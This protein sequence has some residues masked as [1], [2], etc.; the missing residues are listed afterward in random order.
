MTLDRD[1]L[2]RVIGQ[3]L[4]GAVTGEPRRVGAASV[5]QALAES[6]RPALPLWLAVAAV[7]LVAFA[8]TLRESWPQRSGLS[9]AGRPEGAP[10]SSA[11]GPSI[12]SPTPD[13]EVAAAPAARVAR[14][15]A[16]QVK[17]QAAQTA[18][19]A[20]EP[21]FEGLPRLAIARLDPPESLTPAELDSHPLDIE[22]IEIS[23]LTSSDL[24]TE[25]NH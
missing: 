9:V 2:D 21:L 19:A 24:F 14:P 4:T 20:S 18:V 3:A 6:S 17:E 23:P 16:P 22:G 15:F 12:P 7:L 25:Q 10:I 13:G 5:R 11:P 8:V 1:D